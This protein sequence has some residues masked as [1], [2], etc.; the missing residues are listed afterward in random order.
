MTTFVVGDIQGCYEEFRELLS[1]MGFRER[2]DTL[3]LVGDLVNRGPQN[4]E[5]MQYVMSLPSVLS[6]L[7]NHDLHFLAVAC[8]LQRAMKGDTLDDLIESP[9]LGEVI[10]W[11]RRQPLIH[12]D[13]GLGYVL[14]HAG[15]PPMWPLA[16]CLRYAHEVELVLRGDEYRGFLA[17]MY[18]NQPDT[19]HEDLKGNDRLRIITNYFTRLRYCTA[20]GVLELTHKAAV[21]PAGFVPWFTVPRPDEGAYRILFGHWAALNGETG[22]PGA[23]ALDTGCVWGRALTGMRLDDGRIFSVSSRNQ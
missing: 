15:L 12:A 9:Q 21:Q 13:H 4:L 18:G 6:V 1:G 14:V 22:N 20:Q 2:E 7:G 23:I 5:T 8:G 3:W 19:W 11:L 17:S 10:D 16:A